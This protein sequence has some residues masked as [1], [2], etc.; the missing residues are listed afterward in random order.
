MPVGMFAVRVAAKANLLAEQVKVQSTGRRHN[1]TSFKLRS[2]PVGMF[3]V[4]VAAKANL[5][6][7]QVK[8]RS[9]GRRHNADCEA[10]Q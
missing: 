2:M 5:L 4:R 7:E 6:E 9:T 10:C 1:P 8:V 3:A